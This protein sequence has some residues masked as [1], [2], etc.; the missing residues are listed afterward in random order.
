MRVFLVSLHTTLGQYHFLVLHSGIVV[1]VTVCRLTSMGKSNT[2]CT[3]VTQLCQAHFGK[4]MHCWIY[5]L[6]IWSSLT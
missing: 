1:C 3:S 6:V 4:I 5:F 2:F